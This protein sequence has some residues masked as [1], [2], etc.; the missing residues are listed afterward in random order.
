MRNVS[1][2]MRAYRL[3]SPESA[4]AIDRGLRLFAVVAT[5]AFLS[6][7]AQVWAAP[8]SHPPGDRVQSWAVG[9]IAPQPANVQSYN[10]QTIREIIHT[11]IGGDQIRVRIANTFGSSP[12]VIGEAH[13]AVSSGGAAIA[14]GTDRMLTF[15]GKTSVSIPPGAPA[16]SDPVDLQVDPVSDLAVSIYLPNATSGETTTLFQGSSYV[17][18]AGNFTASAMLPGASVLSQ[19]PFVSG[20]SVL[21]SRPGHAIVAITDSATLV[22]QWPRALA[23]RLNAMHADNLGVVSTAVA[24]NRLLFNSAGPF[25]TQWGPSVLTRFDRDVLAQA[26]AQVV[27]VWIGLNDLAG[28]GAFYPAS[29]H[30]TVDDVIVGLRQLIG[31]AHEYGLSILGCTISPMGGNTS[32]PGFDTPQHEAER[33]A[34]NQ[35][36][37]TSG[38]FDGV[39]DADLVLRDPSQPTHLLPAYDSGDH[40]H[41]NTLGGAA[42]ANSIDLKL[43]R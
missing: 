31:R 5:I 29:E 3:S 22:S 9:D 26:G 37:R 23:D 1:H 34:L 12:L 30:V 16:V 38:A 21:S 39:V 27:I 43:L 8:E 42:V 6:G 33:Q 15:G 36:I 28:D 13:V 32:L 17:S 7:V 41:P 11:S 10:N 18:S 40:L 4:N 35:W 19:W 25:G 24:G 14:T 2:L 20:V